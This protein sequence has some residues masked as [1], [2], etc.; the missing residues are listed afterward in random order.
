[1]LKIPSMFS[2][3]T[4]HLYAVSA[5][6]KQSVL[7][8]WDIPTQFVSVIYN[9]Y[10]LDLNVV[11][12]PVEPKIVLTLGHVTEYKNPLL[13]LEIA[14]E[15]TRVRQD[16]EFLWLGEGNMLAQLQD[17]T[18]NIR[19][20]NFVGHKDNIEDYYQKAYLYLQPSLKESLGISVLDAMSIGIPAIVSNVEGLPETT[21][22]DLSGFICMSNEPEEYVDCILKLISDEGLR[23]EMGTNSKKRAETH[24]S[25]QKQ[26]KNIIELYRSL[27]GTP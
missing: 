3:P 5:Y 7:K 18:K 22:H 1:M 26:E 19:N 17:L 10:R 11:N 2:S 15:V 9:S 4:K 21:I 25:P 14:K 12:K 8:Y 13:W 27:T 20:I 24:F 23:S 6:V 16:V